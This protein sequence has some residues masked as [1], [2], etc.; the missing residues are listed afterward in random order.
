MRF[1]CWIIPGEII[2]RE[3]WRLTCW[4]HESIKCGQRSQEEFS[5]KIFYSQDRIHRSLY[6][7]PSKSRITRSLLEILW[8]GTVRPDPAPRGGFVVL[9]III[10][11]LEC[12][13]LCSSGTNRN[14]A[15]LLCDQK[16][17]IIVELHSTANVGIDLPLLIYCRQTK[18]TTIFDRS[19]QIKIFLVM[20][21]LLPPASQ[22][23]TTIIIIIISNQ[24]RPGHQLINSQKELCGYS[25]N[26]PRWMRLI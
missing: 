20:N 25:N 9:W 11:V 14:S 7:P 3:S 4:F 15:P 13:Q 23:R 18:R 16:I 17:P 2:L 26:T 12:T 8:S 21:T 24:T 10:V 22:P 1:D 19:N 6:R 5:T